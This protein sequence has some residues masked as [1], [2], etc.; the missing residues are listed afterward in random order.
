MRRTGTLTTMIV[1]LLAGLL[2]IEAFVRLFHPRPRAQMVRG[3]GLHLI[4]DVPVWESTTDRYNRECAVE[5]TER[6][7]VLFF[8]SSITFGSDLRA[9]ETFTTSL[10]PRLNRVSPTP[11][12]CMMNFAQSGFSFEQKY[13]IARREATRYRPALIMWEDWVE[14]M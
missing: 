8:G 1:G 13:A 9:D 4:G 3:H 12:F 5:H 10:E 6:I 2:M 14:W 11:G 7:R